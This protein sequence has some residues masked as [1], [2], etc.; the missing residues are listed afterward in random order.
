MR[1][2]EVNRALLPIGLIIVSSW[3]ALAAPQPGRAAPEIMPLEQVH[4]GMHGVAYTVFE[5]SKPEPMDVEILG[6]EKNIN[7]P[8]SDLILVR[9]HGT[10]PEFTGV[11]AGMSGSPV[12][13]DGKLI[14]ALS[15]RIGE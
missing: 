7:G 15:Y 4:A 14:G 6:V 3:T 13:V 10:K 11:V 8:K 2:F 9:L 1:R 5:G 12:Y